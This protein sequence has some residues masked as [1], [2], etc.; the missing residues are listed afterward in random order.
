MKSIINRNPKVLLLIFC[1]F[2]IASNKAFSQIAVEWYKLFGGSNMDY[3][4]AFEQT[5]DGGYVIAGSTLS[6]DGDVTTNHGQYDYWV[7]KTDSLRNIQWQKCYG[8]TT[9]DEANS[10]RITSD[11]GY[12]LA[13]YSTSTGGDVTGNH[14]YTD[15]WIVKLDSSGNLQWQKSLG[16]SIVEEANSVKETSDGGYIIA[17]SSNSH[18]FDVTCNGINN[19]G[20]YWVVKLDANGNIQWSNCHGGMDYDYSVAFEQVADCGYIST[21]STFS[22]T[23]SFSGNHGIPDSWVIK[24]DSLGNLQWQKCLGGTNLEEPTSIQST[25]DHGYIVC[26]NSW[27]ND[28]DVSGNHGG[29]DIWIVKL[30]STGNLQWQKC[31]GGSDSEW[32]T[33]VM[34]TIDGAY[35]VVGWTESHDG[36]VSSNNS[37]NS[38]WFVKLDGNGNIQW[39]ECF[40]NSYFANIK[41]IHQN[42][43]GSYIAV[44]GNVDFCIVKFTEFNNSITGKLFID[45]N[46]NGVQDSA[47]PSVNQNYVFELNTGKFSF[48]NSNGV[49]YLNVLDTGIFTMI[50]P[51]NYYN[52]VPASHS[53]N[54]TGFDQTDSLNDFAY[55]PSGVYNDLCAY[56]TPLGNFR[57]GFNANYIITYQNVGTTTLN[58]TV[59]FFP[60]TNLSFVGS[61]VNPT[62]VNTDSVVWNVDTLTPFQVG[63]ILVTVHV[64]AGTL[65]GTLINSTVRI[66]PY[67]GDA[68]TDCNYSNWGVYTTGAY[69]PNAILV[70]RNTVLTNELTNPPNLDYIIYFQNTGN[71]T[72]FNVRVLNN[73]S[74]KLDV[75]TFEFVSSSHPINISYDAPS[76]L[77][78]FTFNNILLPDSSMNESGSHGFI[79]YRI[80]PDSTLTVGDSI[81]NTTFIY[82]DFNQP[83]QTNTAITTII[84]PTGVNPLSIKYSQLN[85]FPNPATD[86][87]ELRIGDFGFKK[88]VNLSVF[89]LF[90]REV[91]HSKIRNQ[92]SAFKIDVSDFSYGVYFIQLQSGDETFRVKFL[93][94]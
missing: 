3:A 57:A 51:L 66:E 34:Q 10:I 39:E 67:A 4:R 12:V 8:G 16:G 55:Q 48:S 62:S 45:A 58:G 47:E 2:F 50:S 43:D 28:G 87:C 70:D 22:S 36:D 31:L 23:G 65:I 74:N 25:S 86:L 37:F 27:S 89:D 41:T 91:Y 68:N 60:D 19:W 42:T 64:N 33:F 90:G 88:N 32:G 73:L 61:N 11:G 24:T 38:S 14:G 9:D 92:Q 94:H 69:D 15:Y 78:T 46:I 13:G 49:Y 63:S 29:R 85:V 1:L 71:D 44:G 93:K 53:I 81:K 75:S 35:M 30:D 7:V 77:M 18:D 79:R 83:V 82:F 56:L 17:G 20:E 54:F 80:K 84:L 76:R 59:I 26:S 72:A 21:G 40:N 52:T 6:I 5:A